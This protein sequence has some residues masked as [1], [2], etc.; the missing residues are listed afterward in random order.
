MTM[1]ARKTM[2][3]EEYLEFEKTAEARHEFVDG[4]LI[5]MPGESY[6]HND[7]VGDIYI[8]L[9]PIAKARGCRIAFESI[10][11]P[12]RGTRYRYP[13]ISVSC[14]PEPDNHFLEKPC[15]I[16]EV[17]SDSTSDTDHGPKLE[18]YS[19]LPFMQCYAIVSQSVRQ[20]VLYTRD[21]NEWKFE[22]LT[23]SGEFSIPCLETTLSLEQI[24][25]SLEPG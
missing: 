23:G 21:G 12:T 14:E 20:V 2:S 24:Y 11:T 6:Q 17:I 10:K 7:I 4:R 25:A 3:V 1:L 16:V 15:F 18:E 8:A 22:V 9:K 5:Q 13:D 19:K